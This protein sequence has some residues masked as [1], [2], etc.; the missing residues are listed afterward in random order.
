[1]RISSSV[2]GSKSEKPVKPS[3]R[4]RLAGSTEVKMNSGKTIADTT[5]SGKRRAPVTSAVI[6]ATPLKRAKEST[7]TGKAA[8]A[9]SKDKLKS[10]APRL[11]P[12]ASVGETPLRKSRPDVLA[13]STGI[14]RALAF[15]A[16]VGLGPDRLMMHPPPLP[17]TQS[18]HHPIKLQELPSDSSSSDDDE[19]VKL[20][21]ASDQSVLRSGGSGTDSDTSSGSS[22]SDGG[23]ATHWKIIPH[24]SPTHDSS[25]EDAQPTAPVATVCMPTPA[26]PL[27]PVEPRR[28]PTVTRPSIVLAHAASAKPADITSPPPRRASVVV[29]SQRREPFIPSN[30]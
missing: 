30:K 20:H 16:P 19:P 21:S 3:N 11:K 12:S 10:P 15:V 17:S 26:S 22:A 24:I 14:G 4:N 23:T 7:G 1:M 5:A 25:D 13:P 28:Q 18:L 8:K 29:K 6:S 9:S 27:K 2:T